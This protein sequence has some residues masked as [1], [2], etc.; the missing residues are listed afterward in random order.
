MKDGREKVRRT[1][2]QK[3]RAWVFFILTFGVYNVALL[4][5]F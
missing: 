3:N 2:K 4:P 1:E 5:L